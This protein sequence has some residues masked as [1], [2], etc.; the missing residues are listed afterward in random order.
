MSTIV[1]INTY[2][3][4]CGVTNCN[5]L[6]KI[7]E[8]IQPEVIFEEIPPSFYNLYYKDKTKSTLES[9][10]IIMYLAGHNI[11]HIPVD[12]YNIPKTFFED[13]GKV[14]E[15]IERRSRTYRYLIDKNKLL[16]TQNGFPYL[17]SVEYELYSSELLVEI[18]ATLKGCKDPKLLQF[19]NTWERIEQEREIEMINNIYKYSTEHKYEKAVFLLG[20]GHRVSIKEKME[21]R[22]KDGDSVLHWNYNTFTN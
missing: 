18:K 14:H 2:H 11:Q 1:L 16:M 13:T 17:N 9:R 19:W 21:R 8:K 10:T 7:L 3:E 6:F 20:A 5:E 22:E 15:Y 4:E 12:Y